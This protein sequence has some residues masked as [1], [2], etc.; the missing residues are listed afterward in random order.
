MYYDEL[1]QAVDRFFRE[2]EEAMKAKLPYCDVCQDHT[3][4]TLSHEGGQYIERCTECGQERVVKQ[5]SRHWER[6]RGKNG[7]GR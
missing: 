7:G 6:G 1:D 4:H 2:K 5:V 3:K